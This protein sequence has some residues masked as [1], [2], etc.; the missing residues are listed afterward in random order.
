MSKIHYE[1]PDKSWGMRRVQLVLKVTPGFKAAMEGH[2]KRSS[3]I[4]GIPVSQSNAIETTMIQT[5]DD[6]RREA[7]Q[8]N[9][10]WKSNGR[11]YM[12]FK[13]TR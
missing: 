3:I 7:N 13:R 1:R 12:D 11:K 2:V 9:K 10:E 6:I 5:H 8:I 4:A